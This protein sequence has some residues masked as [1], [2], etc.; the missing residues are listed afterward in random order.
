MWHDKW[1]KCKQ[2]G[3]LCPV[4][5][6]AVKREQNLGSSCFSSSGSSV[7]LLSRSYQ[8]VLINSAALSSIFLLVARL[9]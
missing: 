4:F 5:H 9:H 2:I 1:C 7:L 3:E 8:A 6:K